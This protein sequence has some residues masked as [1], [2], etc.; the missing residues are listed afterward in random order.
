[1]GTLRIFAAIPAA[2]AMAIGIWPTLSEVRGTQYLIQFANPQCYRHADHI[3]T[4]GCAGIF[5]VI[6]DFPE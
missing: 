1:M 3:S 4:M 5:G 2:I 6:N